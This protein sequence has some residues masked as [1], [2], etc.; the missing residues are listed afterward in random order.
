MGIDPG[1]G[2][3]PD[4]PADYPALLRTLAQQRGAA[5]APTALHARITRLAD[6]LKLD[7]HDGALL[8]LFAR[9]ALFESWR[10]LAQAVP[11]GG[12]PLTVPILGLLGDVSAIDIENQLEPGSRLLRSGLIEDAGDGDFNAGRLLKRIARAQGSYPDR[13]SALLMPVATASTLQWDD[14][15][16][17]GPLRDLAFDL[18][19]GARR[20]GQGGAACC[21]MVHPAPARAN[22]RALADRLGWQAVI[23]GAMDEEGEEPHRSERLVHLNMLRGMT[24]PGARRLVIVDEADDLFLPGWET[25]RNRSSLSKYWMNQL[26]ENPGAAIIWLT[27]D[28][29]GM[30]ESILRRMTLVLRFDLPTRAVRER[31]LRRH[32]D[33]AGLGLDDHAITRLSALPAAP[34]VLASAASVG[35]LTGSGLDGVQRA[36]ESI[37]TVLGKHLPPE[38]RSSGPYDPAL[39]H[40][41]TDL[42]ALAQRLS[43][44]PERGW[45]LLLSGPSGTGKSAFAHHL[46]ARLGIDV[47]AVRAS[48]LLS[49]YVGETEARISAAFRRCGEA[50]TLLLLDEAD[51][52]LFDRRGATRSWES[53]MV[54]E[55]LRSMEALRATFIAT[56]NLIDRM[57][58][59]TQRRFTL[60][61]SFQSLPR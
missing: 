5:P 34:A 30:G 7:A 29:R 26:V 33:A 40:A 10:A 42:E 61:V 2:A 11:M 54:N 9:N 28:A 14:F 35:S 48:D 4:N 22:L 50:G 41:D 24:P 51:S 13:L 20:A 49:P 59:A 8:A 17:L 19:D 21:C 15:A 1:E 25:A 31:V 57:D 47:E 45:S 23:A 60:R 36:G 37:L 39:S 27:N 55:M 46:G 44:A 58:P 3:P 32:A 56:T 43:C 12:H 38:T 18:L 6:R 52:F 53:A 16:H